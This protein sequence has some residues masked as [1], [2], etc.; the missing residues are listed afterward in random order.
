M[1]QALTITTGSLEETREFARLLAGHLRKG[2]TLLLTGNLGAGKTTFTQA[3]A[4]GLDVRGRVSSPTFVIAREHPAKGEGPGLV[5]VDAYRLED[6]AE[7]DDLDLDSE[8]EDMIT[9]IEWGRGKAEQLS[10][11]YLEIIIGRPE[12]DPEAESRT[13]ELRGHGTDW[14]TRL[15]T[16]GAA[17]RALKGDA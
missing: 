15:E 1:T 8:L 7:L 5:H 12:P 13:Y 11:T 14:D 2:D 4:R 9:V 10:D 16:I 3:L 17:V 6:A